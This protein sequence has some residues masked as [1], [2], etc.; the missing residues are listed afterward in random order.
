MLL[1]FLV[2]LSVLLVLADTRES[3]AVY[4]NRIK[5]LFFNLSGKI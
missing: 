1:K 3:S 4:N 2:W 5:S